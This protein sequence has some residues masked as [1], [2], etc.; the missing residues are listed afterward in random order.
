MRSQFTYQCFVRSLRFLLSIYES[1]PIKDWNVSIFL[2]SLYLNN[3]CVIAH[4]LRQIDSIDFIAD[5]FGPSSKNCLSTRVCFRSKSASCRARYF[6]LW[7]KSVV[8]V[9][10]DVW[11][12]VR[13]ER[14]FDRQFWTGLFGGWALSELRKNGQS[15]CIFFE[16]DYKLA[17]LGVW[18]H[19]VEW[20]E[21]AQMSN[22]VAWRHQ[23]QLFLSVF[24]NA[25]R[26]ILT[27][28][29]IKRLAVEAAKELEGLLLVGTHRGDQVVPS[30]RLQAEFTIRALVGDCPRDAQIRLV[31]FGEV[32]GC[33]ERHRENAIEFAQLLLHVTGLIVK[34]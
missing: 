13:L 12:E 10:H 21:H 33:L 11:F 32:L 34:H 7:L 5:S 27:V 28:A 16:I 4:G 19:F 3:V 25:P 1:V 2:Q 6:P 31:I 15:S 30:V 22:V 18:R 24:K 17:F 8:F 14:V 23:S 26:S 29:L 9:R 20:L